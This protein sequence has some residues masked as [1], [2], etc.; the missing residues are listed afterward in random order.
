MS[1]RKWAA[2]A[3]TDTQSWKQGY[4][5]A[6]APLWILCSLLLIRKNKS[7]DVMAVA[8]R[9]SV[10]RADQLLNAFAMM[11]VYRMLKELDPEDGRPGWEAGE[12]N[13][14]IYWAWTK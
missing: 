1:K 5:V 12:F 13:N 2:H 9:F 7:P 14:I 10:E 4:K 6:P 11:Q 3:W 8:S